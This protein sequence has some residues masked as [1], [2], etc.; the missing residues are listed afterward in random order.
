MHLTE[1]SLVALGPGAHHEDVLH[2][3]GLAAISPNGQWF[4]YTSDKGD[5]REVFIDKFPERGQRVR[6][7]PAISP[8][9]WSL[10][11]DEIYFARY[12]AK[13]AQMEMMAARVAFAPRLT[14]GAPRRLFSGSYTTSADTGRSFTL[15]RDGR[16]FLMVKT[17]PGEPP[18]QGAGFA[19]RLI[20]V[21]NWFAELRSAASRR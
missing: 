1:R 18:S 20:V 7:A 14:A 2:E 13:D 17:P 9:I 21:Q 11:S 5:G 10:G 15:S 4:A 8:P 12:V 16:R 6:V 3:E 19:S